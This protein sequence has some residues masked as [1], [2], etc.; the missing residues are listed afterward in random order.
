MYRPLPVSTV[1][2]FT[3]L[4]DAGEKDAY[5]RELVR[6]LC[7]WQYWHVEVLGPL[8]K[9]VDYLYLDEDTFLALE[10]WHA[11]FRGWGWNALRRQEQGGGCV[12][13]F[14]Y[15]AVELVVLQTNRCPAAGGRIVKLVRACDDLAGG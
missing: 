13:D 10:Y 2:V 11:R 14:G 6:R 5:A 8:V 9:G 1:P 7:R 4:L 15:G 12:L 3:L